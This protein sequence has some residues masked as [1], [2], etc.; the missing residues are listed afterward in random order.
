MLFPHLLSLFAACAALS[1]TL[2]TGDGAG[3]KNLLQNG[4]FE[5]G[6]SNVVRAWDT[7]WPVTLLAKSPEFT[8]PADGAHAGKHCARLHTV[9]AKGYSSFTQSIVPTPKHARSVH[10]EGWVRFDS[11]GDAAGSPSLMMIFYDPSSSAP[12]QIHESRLP[13]GAHGWTRL[14]VDASVPED[15]KTWMVRCGMTGVG[16]SSF[17]DVRLTTS[18]SSVEVLRLLR[19]HGDYRLVQTGASTDP[20]IEFSFP[21]PFE[22]QTPLALNVTSKPEGSIKRLELVSDRENR[23]LRVHLAPS[24]AG[25]STEV[26]M[27]ACVMVREIPR[28]DG[29]GVALAPREK[30][31]KEVALFF[32]TTKGIDPGEPGIRAVAKKFRT[33]T[34][35]EAA[36]DVLG[37]M[38]EN[39]TYAGG[40][41][42]GGKSTFEHK[43]AVCTGHANL[44]ASLFQAAGVPCRILGCLI[45][46]RL[47]EHYIVELWAPK[48]GWRRLESTSE[49]FPIRDD[50][51]LI[52]HI[53][54][55]D[56]DRS[57]GNVPLRLRA[58]N[59]CRADYRMGEDHCWQGMTNDDSFVMQGDE[60]PRIEARARAAFTSWEKTPFE[61]G[62]VRLLTPSPA[63]KALSE[64]ARELIEHVT[65][66]R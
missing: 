61:G 7:V 21:F 58:A 1:A 20:W 46:E 29:K 19:A 8:W 54:Y 40:N 34:L 52:L 60:A 57:A 53:A 28:G 27:D 17:D 66:F 2:P 5:A 63:D 10:L 26:R 41:D 15:A 42:Q 11:D 6:S 30:L 48:E 43:N 47:Q 36:D 64:R 22:G 55:P 50:M 23:Y 9:E 13:K 16:T 12:A 38:R 49:L 25:T 32:D 65:S 39:I 33:G 44:A 35:A 59:D 37:W 56:F 51:H 4:D 31:P 14:A 45:N 24:A 3:A 18:E 62:S